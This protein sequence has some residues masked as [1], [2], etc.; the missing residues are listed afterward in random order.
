[1]S[2]ESFR[3]RKFAC[4]KCGDAY[5]AYPPDDTHTTV[6]LNEPSNEEAVSVI[7]ILHNCATCKTPTTLY[8][9]QPRSFW[10]D[11]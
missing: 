1:M 6:S 2:D 3:K 11:P 5:E 7:K 8:W 4:S 9:Y 10:D